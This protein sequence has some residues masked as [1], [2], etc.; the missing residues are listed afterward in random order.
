MHDVL[1]VAEHVPMDKGERQK[2]ENAK[3]HMEFVTAI[4]RLQLRIGGHFLHE[5]PAAATSWKLKCIRD[6]SREEG[7]HM[8]VADLCMY[9]LEETVD[10]SGKKARAQKPT[11]L[12]ISSAEIAR[13]LGQKCDRKHWHQPLVSGQAARAGEYPRGLCQA[14]CRGLVKQMELDK[15]QVKM[16]LSLGPT[17]VVHGE[18]PPEEDEHEEAAAKARDDVSGKE[19]NPVEV[20]RARLTEM[21][22]VSDKGV[23]DK[24]DRR[25]A[26]KKGWKWSTPG[27]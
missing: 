22:Y 15:K 10:K 4:Y 23:W 12:M 8:T 1:D 24:V 27:G 17:D 14:I 5:H 3:K 25:E 18:V 26:I 11:R 7:V 2:L 9:G 20:K 16:L 21:E 6:L 13:Q 19:L